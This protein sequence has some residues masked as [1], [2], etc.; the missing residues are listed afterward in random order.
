MT[1]PRRRGR[2]LL[3]AV[4]VLVGLRVGAAPA[5]RCPPVDRDD[6]RAAAER[7]VGWFADN[8]R[9]DGR[10]R[11]LSDE[12]GRDLG[13]YNATRHAGVLM[14]LE[15]AVAAGID[16]ARPVADLGVEWAVSRL[17]AAGGG[18]ALPELDG[19]IRTGSAALLLRALLPR[20][21]ADPTLLQDLGRFLAGQVDEDGAVLSAWDPVAE[22]ATGEPSPFFTGEAYWALLGLDGFDDAK[23][24]IGAYLPVRDEVEGRFPPLS[25][26]W[27]TYSYA[28]IGWDDLTDAQRAHADRMA[29]LFG[30]QVRGESTRWE[31][32]LQGL[33]RGGPAGGSGLGTLGEGTGNLLALYGD[34][35]PAG[36]EERLRCVAGMLVA[37]QAPNGAWYTDGVTR[38]DDQ[39][40][41]L[42]ALLFSDGVLGTT[43]QDAV[44]GGAEA[45]PML[46]LLVAAL[47]A[48]NPARPGWT[49]LGLLN[50]AGAAAVLIVV[51]GPL[52]DVLDVT[53][54]SARAAAGIGAA[55]AAIAVLVAPG[56]SATS[57]VVAAS[58]GV[59][60][61]GLGA[62]DGARALVALGV[63]VL[64]ALAWPRGLRRPLL[65]RA[66][67]AV[68]LVLAVDL[69]VDGIL[70]V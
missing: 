61:L 43:A 66:G 69:V 29:G 6:A 16:E 4:L 38:M 13:G 21:D 37:R 45:H 62:D 42:S 17:A 12:D 44:G 27:A 25:D 65:A 3:V 2:A 36:L 10:F 24:R 64:V 32:G 18:Q 40:H 34:D 54:A 23:A 8:Q 59:L 30:M 46:W 53:P 63:A 7:A 67:A 55:L 41:A 57:G 19:A 33:L 22:E 60:A 68:L 48:V 70:G 26:H 39:Q 31:G 51:S 35:A 58:S 50:G 14:S 5:E 56:A 15:Q 52:L 1:A 47:A 28:A 11:Y 49:R 9:R 20:D